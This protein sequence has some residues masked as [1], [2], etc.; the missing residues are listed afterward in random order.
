M[1]GKVL[2]NQILPQR[3]E[4]PSKVAGRWYAADMTTRPRF[5]QHEAL[6]LLLIVLPFTLL[7]AVFEIADTSTT[8]RRTRAPQ[9]TR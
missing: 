4:H 8:H 3:W 7:A 9:A 2:T 5:T 1:T 6:T